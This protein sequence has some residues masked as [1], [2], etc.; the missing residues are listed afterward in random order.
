MLA[1]N[2]KLFFKFYVRP[3][4]ALSDSIDR[5]SLLIGA[6]L[7]TAVA[8]LFAL[9]VTNRLYESYEAVPIP[10]AERRLPKEFQLP[11]QVQGDPEAEQAYREAVAEYEE[12]CATRQD[13]CR[14]R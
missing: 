6:V 9:T 7:V 5:G 13:A 4:S 12:T 3:L 8:S 10:E 11:P 1:E 14:S 2:L